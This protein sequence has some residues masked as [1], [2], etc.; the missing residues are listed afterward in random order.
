MRRTKKEPPPVAASGPLLTEVLTLRL[1]STCPDAIIFIDSEGQIVLANPAACS[2]FEYTAEE[3]LGTDVRVLMAEPYASHH[4]SYIARYEETGHRQAIGR[5]RLV[6]ARRKGGAEF[7][8]E[9]SV[10]Q[11]GDDSLGARYGAFIRDV[12]EKVR[13]QAELMN[14][15]R[16][17]TVGTT[18][19]MLAHEIGNPLNNMALQLQA[20]RR[21]LSRT[22]EDDDAT[23]KVDLCLNE[24][25][26]LSRLVNEFRALS[27]RRRLDRHKIP[28]TRVL[29]AVL[30]GM[31]QR[32]EGLDVVREF[33][34]DGAIVLADADKMQQ[35]FLNLCHNAAEAMPA[36]GKLTLRTQRANAEYIVEVADTGSGIPAGLDIFEPFV[37][38]KADGTGLGLA[39][40]AEIVR[41]HEGS[42]TYESSPLGTTFRLRLPLR[43]VEV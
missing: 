25:E 26:R 28:L 15:E 35:V 27:G 31:F 39:I 8:I 16:V 21:R 20:L 4:T 37:T 10:A 5:I 30:A 34:D 33:R 12:S 22:G 23:G 24:V 6:S 3:L 13:L 1:A 18:A 19:S 36:G 38:T 41:E 29:E 11:L 14:R 43:N 9:L 40:C 2:M 42:L 17:A 32:R 7:P